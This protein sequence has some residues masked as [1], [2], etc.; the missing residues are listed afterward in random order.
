MNDAKNKCLLTD[1]CNG[2]TMTPGTPST[3]DIRG[4]T[5]LMVSG[6]GAHSWTYTVQDPQIIMKKG[7]KYSIK[8]DLKDDLAENCQARVKKFKF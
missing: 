2:V 6:I 5:V 7:G 3:Y 1:G 8:M 4:G